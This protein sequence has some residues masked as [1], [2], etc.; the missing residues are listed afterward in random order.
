MMLLLLLLLKKLLLLLLLK[1][2]VSWELQL[3]LLVLLAK[4]GWCASDCGVVYVVWSF[5]PLNDLL[6]FDLEKVKWVAMSWCSFGWLCAKGY[7]W[8]VLGWHKLRNG[9]WRSWKLDGV[10]G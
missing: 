5:G 9:G 8:F 6:A 2:K 4:H 10:G 7:M 1:V 3:W